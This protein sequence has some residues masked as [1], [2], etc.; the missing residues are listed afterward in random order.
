[1]TLPKRLTEKFIITRDLRIFLQ[2]ALIP[3]MIFGEKLGHA[4]LNPERIYMYIMNLIPND[5][6][7]ILRNETV[8]EPFSIL[9]AAIRKALRK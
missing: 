6:K 7:H 1:M 4:N 2:P 9:F 8:N 3:Y 5:C